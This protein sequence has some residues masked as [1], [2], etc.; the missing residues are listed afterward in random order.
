MK[1]YGR[2]VSREKIR[3][4]SFGDFLAWRWDVACRWMNNVF[5]CAG[6]FYDA[7]SLLLNQLDS[8][9]TLK[10]SNDGGAS[11]THYFE[12]ILYGWREAD[13]TTSRNC[14]H[15]S[16]MYLL[17]QDARK[18]LLSHLSHCPDRKEWW[19]TFVCFLPYVT[20]IV[21]SPTLVSR[22]LTVR[23]PCLRNSFCVIGLST[24]R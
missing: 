18:P 21:N 7:E 23:P 5:H 4:K 19:P 15:G 13:R 12:K 22:A 9:R 16:E 24:V 10:L 20:C 2:R 11:L 3:Q 14:G 8:G 1:G 6:L 17:H